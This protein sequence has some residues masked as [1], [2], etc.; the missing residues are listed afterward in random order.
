MWQTIGSV[1][2]LVA[3]LLLLG[4]GV[5]CLLVAYRRVGRPIGVDSR[6]DAW[7]A[8]WAGSLKLIGWVWVVLMVAWPAVSVV[9]LLGG[10]GSAG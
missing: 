8:Q 5:Y 6:Y 1:W 4:F 7:H 2:G 9:A 3:S 10:G